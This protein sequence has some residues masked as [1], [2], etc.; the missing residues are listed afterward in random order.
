MMNEDQSLRGR[1]CWTQEELARNLR[2]MGWPTI[3][4]NARRLKAR[5]PLPNQPLAK[6]SL[7]ELLPAAA[8]RFPSG[9]HGFDLAEDFFHSIV[10]LVVS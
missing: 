4:K 1:F 10:N 8:C 6:F 7:S 5:L 3:W 9:E 2:Q